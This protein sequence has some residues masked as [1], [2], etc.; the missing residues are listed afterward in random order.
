LRIDLVVKFIGGFD[1]D[2]FGHH[3]AAALFG[4]ELAPHS[5]NG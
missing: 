3:G 2:Q 5:Q 1:A 4:G